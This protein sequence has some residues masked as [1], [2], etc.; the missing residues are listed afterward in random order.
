MNALRHTIAPLARDGHFFSRVVA[1]GSHM[2]SMAMLQRG[3]VAVAAVDCVTFELAA[4]H[5]P[6]AVAGLRILQYSQAAPGLPL[7]ASRELSDA[8]VQ[9]LLDTVLELPET[10]PS[11]LGRLAIRRFRKVGL[12]DY[13]PI[14]EQAGFAI[15]RGYPELR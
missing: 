11:V 9:D 1:S 2:A 13:K 8:Q 12:A 7:I 4:R 15:E 10:A 5:A 3:Q 6:G 14:R